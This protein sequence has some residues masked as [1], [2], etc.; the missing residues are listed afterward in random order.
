M[1]FKVAIL[2]ECNFL[3]NARRIA[4]R[5]TLETAPGATALDFAA[6][7]LHLIDKALQNLR[8]A[9]QFSRGLGSLAHG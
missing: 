1:P 7:F 3:H 8:L 9:C 2:P 6:F 4:V 5:G